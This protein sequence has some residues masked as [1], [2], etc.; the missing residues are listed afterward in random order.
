MQDS[1]VIAQRR[2]KLKELRE[3]GSAYPND[4]SRTHVVRQLLNQH[5]ALGAEELE[6]QQPTATVAGRLLRREVVDGDTLAL[7]EDGSGV[8][9]VCVSNAASGASNHAAFRQWD[10]GDIVGVMGIVYRTPAGEL[11]LRAHELRLLV[12]SLRVVPDQPDVRRLVPMRSR[13]IAGIRDLMGRTQYMEVE[14]PMLHP[15]PDPVDATAPLETYHHALDLK[16]YLRSG[17]GLYLQRLLIGGIEKVYEIN[18]SF[19][20]AAG[21]QHAAEFTT[22]ELYC[23]YANHLYMISLLERLIGHATMHALGTTAVSCA[24]KQIDL[25]APFAM[26]TRV[27]AEAA[28]DLI[29][30]TVVLDYPAQ[31]APRSR[32]K[33]ADPGLAEHFRIFIGGAAIAEGCSLI[34]HPEPAAGYDADFVRALEYGMPPGAGARLDIDRML[35]IVTGAG[36]PRPC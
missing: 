31:V 23:A 15:A 6:K 22:M 10:L 8:L 27:Q 20:N 30:P 14:T 36:A 7:V 11:T 16:L 32:R 24:G 21:E 18:R 3:S 17:P 33:D 12:K 35:T 25:G 34:N 13:F 1:T 9:Q 26:L 4:F 28:G 19:S 2:A 5:A 29:A